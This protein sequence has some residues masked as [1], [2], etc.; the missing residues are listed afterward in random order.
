MPEDR[1][2]IAPSNTDLAGDLQYLNKRFSELDLEYQSFDGHYQDI[3]DFM[4]P[5]RG[6]FFVQDVNKG[7]KRHKNILNNKAGL[8]VRKATA[9]M[10]A[11]VMSPSRPWFQYTIFDKDL[12]AKEDVR[13]WL[14][15]L[16]EL[17]LIIARKSNLYSEAAS[18]IRELL[19]FGT[20]CMT[21]V[22]DF[23]DVARF[24]THTT[25]SF[26][27][28]QNDRRIVDTIGREEQYTT[29]QLI[30][31]F[32][33]ENVSEAVRTQYDRGNYLSWHTVRHMIEPNPMFDKSEWGSEFMPFRSVYFEK[34][35]KIGSD[36]KVPFLDRSGFE[37]FPA[38]VLRWQ[39]TGNDVFATDCPGMT[40]L[41]DVKQL[42]AQEREKAKAIAKSNTPP[43][44]APPIFRNQPINQLP[45][46]VT[47]S[48]NTTTGQK[49]E[50]LYQVDPRVRELL[51]DIEATERRIDAGFFVDMFMAIT[52]QPGIQP[53]NELQLSQINEERLLQIGPVLEQIHGEWLDRMVRRIT[54]RVFEVDLMPPAPKALQGR[55]LDVE[56][57]SALAIAQRSVSISGIERTVNFAAG[58]AQTGVNVMDRIDGDKTLE[59]Y[60]ILVGASPTILVPDEVAMARRAERQKQEEQARQMEMGQ[61]VAN[62]AK[63]AA[64]AKLS[65]D[66][67]VSRTIGK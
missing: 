61:Q 56:F 49:I 27:I 51:F 42:Q 3:S 36:G 34:G 25:G 30:R 7:T 31:E 44:Q 66:N 19:L 1:K 18:M 54:K 28:A 38:Y 60:S 4:D 52:E 43:L 65:D 11:G 59:E 39:V 48:V 53:K 37:G 33:Y 62:M 55:E 57:T 9:G 41:G 67:I 46:G 17:I 21:H 22:N 64:D 2:V 20:G 47:T 10:I 58:L 29:I 12:M 6:R 24:Y 63:M 13:V 16:R 26:R 14:W 5:R 23:N 32:G 50:P 45:N 35:A 40:T 15:Q 8:A